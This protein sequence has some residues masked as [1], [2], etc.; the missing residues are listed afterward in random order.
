MS[1]A[2]A[3]LVIRVSE[4]VH[5]TH[6]K[7]AEKLISAPNILQTLSLVHVRGLRKIKAKIAGKICVYTV[8]EYECVSI[9]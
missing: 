1:T 3:E 8:C 5:F 9:P 6:L 7:M 2:Q 4:K